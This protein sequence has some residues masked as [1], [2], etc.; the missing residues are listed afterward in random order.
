M[1]R[2]RGDEEGYLNKTSATDR[3]KMDFFTNMRTHETQKQETNLRRNINIASGV[4]MG[5]KGK[6]G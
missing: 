2:N 1:N 6:G 4:L 3:K 5:G